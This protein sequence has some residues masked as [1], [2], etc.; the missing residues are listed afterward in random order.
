MAGILNLLCDICQSITQN[1]EQ[2]LVLHEHQTACN[3]PNPDVE[4]LHEHQTAC[5]PPNPD[6]EGLHLPLSE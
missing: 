6:V 3:P 1:M 2:Y 5:N 4:V